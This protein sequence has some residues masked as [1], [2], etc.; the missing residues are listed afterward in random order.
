MD[1]RVLW[2][3]VKYRIRQCTIEYSK[4]KARERKAKLQE[5]EECIKE[6]SHKCDKVPSSQ[7]LEELESLEAEYENLY[8]FI[9][10]G[11]II[12][13]RATWYEMGERNNKYF[14]NLEN[15]NKKKTSVG[16]VFTSEGLLTRDP[17][18]IMNELESYYSSLYDRNSCANSDTISTFISKSNQ[19]P[20]LPEN[21]RNICEGKLGY[22]E[23]YNVLK[24]FQKNKP[25]GNDGLTA[26]FCIAFWPLI[27]ALL[28]DSLNYAFEYGELSY[29][30]KQAIITLIEKKGKDKRL[31]KNWRPI[32]LIKCGCENS[33]KS[34]SKT[35]GKDSS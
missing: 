35:F 7:N 21:L 26:E 32:A 17:K 14:L 3:L 2:D 5:V 34:S 9:T 23:C 10:Q 29:S 18:K 11:A 8:D 19:I 20:K 28:V 4:S 30:Q 27:G 12:R 13:S 15:S 24:S 31:I 33:V 16:K 1:K 25:P 6:C 22:G